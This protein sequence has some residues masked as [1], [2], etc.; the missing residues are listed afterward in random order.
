MDWEKNYLPE[1]EKNSDPE[2]LFQK[3]CKTVAAYHPRDCRED[4]RVAYW[5]ALKAHGDQRR[6]SGEPYITHPLCVSIILAQIRMDKETII[7]A[8][9]HDVIED[10]DISE[11]EILRRF[12]QEILVLV[13]GVTKLTQMSDQMSRREM[14]IA[15]LR[16]MFVAMTRDIRII[17]VKL[18]DRLHNLRTLEFQPPARQREIAQETLDIYVPLADRLG[19]SVLK[20][21]LEDLSL[22]YLEPGKYHEIAVERARVCEMEHDAVDGMAEKVKSSLREA[23]IKAK[24]GI[25][26]RHI[27]SLYRKEYVHG[28]AKARD[29]YTLHITVGS[30]KECYGALGVLHDVFFPITGKFKDYIALPKVNKYRALHS[31]VIGSTGKAVRVHIMTGEMERFARYGVTARWKY[32]GRDSYREVSRREAEKQRW[33]SD[34]LEWQRSIDNNEMF[35][36]AVQND[37]N[38]FNFDMVCFTKKGDAVVLPEGAS[39]IDFAYKIH[40]DIGNKAVGA[41]VGG[42]E[43]G[44]EYRLKNGEQVEIL[45]SEE[46]PGPRAEWLKWVKTTRARNKIRFWLER[47]PQA[48]PEETQRRK[49]ARENMEGAGG[50]VSLAG[51]CCPAPGDEICCY[52]NAKGRTIIHRSGCINIRA[53]ENRTLTDWSRIRGKYKEDVKSRVRIRGKNRVGFLTDLMT[54]LYDQGNRVAELRANTEED[55]YEA[56]MVLFVSDAG[57]I[58]KIC[59]KIKEIDGVT[60]AERCWE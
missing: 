1:W 53:V 15:S 23:G 5:F 20:D 25:H 14:K 58:G 30:I 18:A 50:E 55:S 47:H 33:L 12:G 2:R 52:I 46:S 39:I 28:G 21:E 34:I 54:L 24:T 19:V 48:L 60:L 16:K 7:A 29:Y 9:L 51:C 45:T 59:E 31:R 57:E 27:F 36:Q 17:F 38:V 13:D 42:R 56:S 40:T 43:T 3:L 41:K 35:M 32:R 26:V 6:K 37:L 44:L 4:L 11:D 22:L 49:T 8:L 10:T